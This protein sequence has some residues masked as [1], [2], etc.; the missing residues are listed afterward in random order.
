MSECEINLEVKHV[1]NIEKIEKKLLHY[2]GKAI[3]DFKLI[4]HG[5]RV[6]VCLSGG[7]DSFTMLTIL[8]KLQQRAKIKFELFAFTLDQAQPGWAPSNRAPENQ[9]VLLSREEFA[10]AQAP[11]RAW[12]PPAD[13]LTCARAACQPI[14][15][16]GSLVR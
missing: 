13:T 5:D 15:Q 10:H 1:N 7:K 4:E 16:T 11:P 9:A 12:K 14:C 6:M 2:V 8:R 3:A